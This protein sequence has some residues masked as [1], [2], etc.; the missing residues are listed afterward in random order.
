M[1]DHE[2]LKDNRVLV[3]GG[4]T[5]IGRET[6]RLLAGRGARVLTFGR[7][8]A[9]LREALEC[10]PGAIG[11]TADFSTIEGLERVFAEVDSRLG[12]IDI[13]VSC[14]ALGAEPIHEMAD[15]DWRYV[16]DTNLRVDNWLGGLDILVACAGVGSGPLMEMDDAGWRHVIESNLVSYVA[17]TKGP[18]DRS[19]TSGTKDGM[20]ILVGSISVN[21]QAV[22]ESVYNAG[23]GGV[24]SFAETLRKE[25]IPANFRLTLI[26][27][28]AIASAM[29]PFPPEERRRQME[30]YK[31]LP[32]EQVAEAILFAATRP[33]G[34]D[35][36]TLR[37]EPLDQKIY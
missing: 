12:G 16:I 24:A 15:E 23:K 22:G 11:L 37:I 33:A 8:P 9:A 1:A 34:I 27:P 26:E 35:V 17:C 29:Q 18:I 13:L 10:A 2:K 36:V 31:M 28:G 7:D 4:T 14:A 25:L 5:G 30:A 19:K 6:V 3:T 32:P 21:I 20:I